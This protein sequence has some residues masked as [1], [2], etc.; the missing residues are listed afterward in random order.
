MHDNILKSVGTGGHQSFLFGGSRSLPRS[1]QN[2]AALFGQDEYTKLLNI[3]LTAEKKAALLYRLYETIQN[4]PLE[5]FYAAHEGSCASLQRMIFENRGLIKEHGI[6]ITPLMSQLVAKAT[7]N[8][9]PKWLARSAAKANC[10]SFERYLLSRYQEA[11]RLA[12]AKDR[13]KIF[14]LIK[15]TKGHILWLSS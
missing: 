11:Y 7:I 4:E 15:S 12:P 14:A 2:K 5:K 3:L 10:T 9:S 13:L 1:F 8:Y 6:P